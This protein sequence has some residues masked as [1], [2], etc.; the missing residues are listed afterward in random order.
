MRQY[1]AFASFAIIAMLA[2]SI[3]IL[4]A[5]A[6]VPLAETRG[7]RSDVVYG[8]DTHSV[9]LTFYIGQNDTA[10]LQSTLDTLREHNVTE[11]VFFM[12]PSVQGSPL[13]NATGQAGYTVLPWADAGQYDSNYS[14]TSFADIQLSDRS[15]LTRIN[16]MADI[17]AFYMLALHSSSSSIIA[18]TPGDPPAFNY[19]HAVLEEVLNGGRGTLVFTAEPRDA[20]PQAASMEVER[21]AAPTVASA[22]GSNTTSI[23]EIGSGIWNLNSLAARYPA[24]ISTVDI[25]GG[26]TGYLIDTTLVIEEGAQLNIAD[27]NVLIA[28]PTAAGDRDRRIEIQGGATIDNAVISSW[29]AAAGAPDANPYH[30][31]PFIFVDEGTLEMTNSTVA[32]MGF[33]LGGL[34][35]VRSARAAVMLHDSANSTIANSTLAFNYDAFYARNSSFQLTGN[36]IYGNTRSGVDIRS[37]SHDLLIS[38]NHVHDNGYEGISCTECTRAVIADNSVEHNKEAGIKLFSFVNMTRVQDNEV[39]HNEKF[40]VYLKDNS[41]DNVVRGNFITESE[42]GITLTGSSNNNTILGNTVTNTDEAIVMDETSRS[43]VV[44][45]N[46]LDNATATTTANATTAAAG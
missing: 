28:S 1:L 4:P 25:G 19:T 3:I 44:R 34:S 18:F 39:R 27:A 42:E 13:A 45:N 11:A 43:N 31:R 10:R 23:I 22:V 41:T 5:A 37:G 7:P 16:K 35:E 8:A 33:P 40:G 32:H 2:C 17:V 14:P 46:Q 26:G 20:P 6:Q 29:D 24:E 12:H 21:F 9:T 15:I 30:Q 38:E 36:E